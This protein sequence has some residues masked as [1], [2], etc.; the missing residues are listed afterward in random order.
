MIKFERITF[1]DKEIIPVLLD[2][3]PAEVRLSPPIHF[4]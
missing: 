1:K 3:A 2:I 4:L